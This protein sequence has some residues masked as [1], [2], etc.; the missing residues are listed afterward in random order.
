MSHIIKRLGR[1]AEP[2]MV[3]S[4]HS[5]SLALINSTPGPKAIAATPHPLK[6]ISPCCPGDLAAAR[7]WSWPSWREAEPT[8]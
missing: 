3:Y 6:A 2:R 8:R 4:T 5:E 7:L 1:S